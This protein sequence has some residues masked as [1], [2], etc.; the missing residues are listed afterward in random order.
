GCKMKDM[1]GQPLVRCFNIIN[2]VTRQPAPNPVD[3][4][5][6]EGIVV[7]L[8]NHTALIKPDGTETPI[9][10]SAAPIKNANGSIIGVIM[11]F[12]DV[13][14]ERKAARELAK[15]HEEL[16]KVN[17]SLE[18]RVRERTAELQASEERARLLIERVV[19]YAIFQLDSEGR[20]AS[21]NL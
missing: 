19:D 6:R 10:D 11:V 4:V 12:H 16:G 5:L 3:R 14:A 8:A 1:L 17:E 21:W 13:S 18:L 7:G 9:E 20:V 15:A 2:E